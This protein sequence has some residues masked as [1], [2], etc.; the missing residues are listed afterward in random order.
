[1]H[2]AQA[3]SSTPANVAQIWKTFAI[4]GK[5]TSIV[6]AIARKKGQPLKSTGNE[7][8]SAQLAE[9]DKL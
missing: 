2:H 8:A 1:M 4:S 7:I 5:I 6:Q 9:N 3:Y